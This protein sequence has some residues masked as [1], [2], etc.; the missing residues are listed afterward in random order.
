MDRETIAF[1]DRDAAAYSDHMATLARA[2]WTERFLGGLAA[3]SDILDLGCGSGWA[4]ARFAAAGHR[5]TALDA[6]EGLAAEARARYGLAVRVADFAD[7]D[8]VAAYDAVWASF[9]LLHEPRGAM[10]GHLARIARAL[11]PS[12]L[13]YL[14]LKEGTGETR[15]RLGRLYVYHGEAEIA[16]LL[17]DAGFAVERSVVEEGRGYAG[18]AARFLHVIARAD[19]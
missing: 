1:Y 9:S 6:S 15:D 16:G 3:G 18:D 19:G 7:L 4:A 2:T 12:G 10:P 13:L 17:A 14:G 11:R 8:E 5:V